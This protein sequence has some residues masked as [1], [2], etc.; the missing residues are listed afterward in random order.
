MASTPPGMKSSPFPRPTHLIVGSPNGTLD[1]SAPPLTR[2]DTQAR[3]SSASKIF[4]NMADG[5]R[6]PN[7]VLPGRHQLWQPAGHRS[8]SAA[9]SGRI[10]GGGRGLAASDGDGR[11]LIMVAGH[12]I[13]RAGIG[14]RSARGLD[15]SDMLPPAWNSF[16]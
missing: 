8:V 11:R 2:I 1:L 4:R 14:C 15:S 16:A 10:H 5:R 13:G 12:P 3:R 9:G 7:T 6:F